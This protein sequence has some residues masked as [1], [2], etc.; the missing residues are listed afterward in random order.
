MQICNI[1][2]SLP[3][4]LHHNANVFNNNNNN[5]NNATAVLHSKIFSGSALL[6]RP[7]N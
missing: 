4:L 7:E 5:N 1:I 3:Q 6:A 2:K